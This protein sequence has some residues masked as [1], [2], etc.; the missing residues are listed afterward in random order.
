MYGQR[1]LWGTDSIEYLLLTL[2]S[3]IIRTDQK[4]TLNVLF[5][6]YLPVI[7]VSGFSDARYPK[8]DRGC[9]AL[10]CPQLLVSTFLF[11][12]VCIVSLYHNIYALLFDQHMNKMSVIGVSVFCSIHRR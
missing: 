10:V 9:R 1:D 5:F 2:V 4:N 11:V 12:S 3:I 6:F 8:C 7:Q